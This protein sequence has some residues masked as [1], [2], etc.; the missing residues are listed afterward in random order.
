MSC[1]VVTANQKR[2]KFNYTYSDSVVQHSGVPQGSVLGPFCF[3]GY[4]NDVPNVFKCCK[5]KLYVYDV[6]LYFCYSPGVWTNLLQRDLNA[7]VEWSNMWHMRISVPKT[8]ILLI[9][10]KNIG[11]VH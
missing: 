2:V 3:V 9:G 1:F 4:M 6:K 10:S 11:N 7:V 8:F 5:L